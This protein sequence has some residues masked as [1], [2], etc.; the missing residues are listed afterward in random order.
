M[1][2]T[3]YEAKERGFGFAPP[4]GR[5]GLPSVTI[6]HDA[7]AWARVRA[8][9]QKDEVDVDS[10]EAAAAAE[11]GG[12]EPI[13][14]GKRVLL[15]VF[16]GTSS[17]TD[18]RPFLERLAREGDRVLVDVAWKEDPEGAPVDALYEPWLVA[19]APAEPFS[20]EPEVELRVQG[21]ESPGTVAHERG[22]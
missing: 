22:P 19:D 11:G 16:A 7:A 21:Q 2:P 6:V 18:Q 12:G 17:G 13:D 3:Q 4:S 8:A 1:G 5:H 14:W 20:G 9:L 15:V 10:A